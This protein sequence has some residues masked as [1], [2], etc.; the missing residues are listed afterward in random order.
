[1]TKPKALFATRE[2]DLIKEI[3]KEPFDIEIMFLEDA[4]SSPTG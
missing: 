4:G 1:V 3:N 2:Q